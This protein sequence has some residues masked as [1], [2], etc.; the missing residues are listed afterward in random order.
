MMS[1]RS[2]RSPFLYV[3]GEP[4]VPQKLR[5]TG[6]DERNSTGVPRVIANCAARKT[7]NGSEGAD[8]ALRHV[9]QWQMPLVS[10]SPSMR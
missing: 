10:G 8:A 2:A 3:S 5:V 6:A 7:T 4:H 9:S 1:M